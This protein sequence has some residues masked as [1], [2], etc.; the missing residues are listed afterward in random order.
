M[1]VDLVFLLNVW[2]LI[3]IFLPI[4]FKFGKYSISLSI[5]GFRRNSMLKSWN[6]RNVNKWPG[7]KRPESM[8][9]KT[10][11]EGRD[12]A[13]LQAFK[14]LWKDKLIKSKV[15]DP[16]KNH[17][18]TGKPRQQICPRVSSIAAPEPSCLDFLL[19]YRIP[20]PQNASKRAMVT[21]S[22]KSTPAGQVAM[23]GQ[24]DSPSDGQ[25][26]NIGK[27]LQNSRLSVNISTRQTATLELA[28]CE[29]STSQSWTNFVG[30][31][32]D[33]SSE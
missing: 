27:N 4:F 3:T 19:N 16:E 18:F 7:V 20:R 2:N 15:V 14:D 24:K 33:W 5:Q 17:S 11:E 32:T 13:A 25:F 8:R 28:K 26:Q 21:E 30:H 12:E 31:E 10:L 1:H 9:N 23:L 6:Q 29:I 22:S